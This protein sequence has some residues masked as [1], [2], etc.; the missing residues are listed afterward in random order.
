MKKIFIMIVSIVLLTFSHVSLA[1]PLAAVS[2]EG[3]GRLITTIYVSGIL[4]ASLLVLILIQMISNRRKLRASREQIENIDALRKTFMNASDEIVYLK[5][6]KL[7]YVFVNRAFEEFF[8]VK[9]KDIVGK[10]DFSIAQDDFAKLQH[11]L[12]LDAWTKKVSIVTEISYKNG[13]YEVT[14]FP[15]TMQNGRLGLGCYFKDITESRRKEKERTKASLRNQILLEVFSRSFSDRQELLDYTLNESLKLMG[16]K[17]GYIYL[18]DEAK[19]QFTLNSWSHD[20][21][22]DCR[23][24]KP[25]SVYRLETTGLWGEVVRQRKPI[26]L[27][28]FQAP[29]ARKK[30]YPQGHVD[31]VRFMSIPLFIEGRIVAAAGFAN[32]EDAYSDNDVYEMTLLMSGVWNAVARLDALES[33]S[34]ER[35]KSLQTLMSI[36]EG[37]MVVDQSGRVEML[38]AVAE[39]LC[40]Y[41][42]SQAEGRPYQE[43]FALSREDG[44]DLE[45]PVEAALRTGQSQHLTGHAILTS[46]DGTRYSLEDSA[47]PIKDDSGNT[48]GVVIVFRD[49]TKKIEQQRYIEY[50]S[51]HDS[52]TGLYNRRFFEEEM[53]RLDTQRNLPITMI[54]VDVN[55]LKL[56]NDIFGHSTGDVLLKK[57][58][59]SL[60]KACRSDDIIAR[61]GGDEFVLLLPNTNQN[62]AESIKRRIKSQFAKETIKGIRGSV[63][64]GYALKNTMADDLHEILNQA[65]EQMYIN[66]TLE[67]DEVKN[68]A[69]EAILN[70]F[71]QHSPDEKEKALRVSVLAEAFAKELQLGEEA[72][73][74][75]KEAAY[76]NDIGKIVMDQ[77]L[78]EKPM[79]LYTE[80]ELQ[81]FRRH[82]L[83][84]Y[85][86]LSFFDVKEE[87]AEAVLSHQERWD[88][89]GFPKQLREE[90]IPF[91]A[92]I[93]LIPIVFDRLKIV[94]GIDQPLPE[95][96]KELR[97]RA[98]KALDPHLTEVFIRMVE[99]SAK[100]IDKQ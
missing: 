4:V 57:V 44:I 43:V 49:A 27:N 87:I 26:I 46:K 66:K 45:D 90:S 62:I 52:L 42:L 58:A 14:K 25:Q 96:L 59:E 8:Q 19:Q 80:A 72:V 88:G 81:E 79:S 9:E 6:E 60:K 53:R 47:A 82:P 98:G 15:V 73:K 50:L 17:Y 86:I 40:G 29:D 63:S 69:L 65:E 35:N 10:D 74:D 97:E 48:V 91:Y 100:Q 12:D 70:A 3:N 38:N 64:V 16:S 36:G 94:D 41:T 84:G 11:D 34:Y 30:G 99:R 18:Y 68:V 92:R 22:E 23:V 56:T 93:I 78:V 33:L 75:I 51:F 7:N 77:K 28:D 67:H 61:W 1:A 31:L 76:L 95:A 39:H 13:V 32:K 24:K 21:M 55:N 54:M 89:E 2:A 20:V 37:V 5:D 85:R 83:V 71:G